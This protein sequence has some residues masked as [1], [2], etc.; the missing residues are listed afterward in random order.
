MNEVYIRTFRN[1]NLGNEMEQAKFQ[2]LSPLTMVRSGFTSVPKGV[3]RYNKPPRKHTHGAKLLFRA[4]FQLWYGCASC[5][6]TS[7]PFVR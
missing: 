2:T 3:V 7:K 5:P 4:D 6:S 1:V